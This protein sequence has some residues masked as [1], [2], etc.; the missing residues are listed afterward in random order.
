MKKKLIVN[1]ILSVM[2]GVSM[3]ACAKNSP[4]AAYTANQA[5]LDFKWEYPA[6]W[7]VQVFGEQRLGFS[8]V[9][10]VEKQ[11]PDL[12][13]QAVF[14]VVSKKAQAYNLGPAPTL[15]AVADD[16]ANRRLK[17]EG[18]RILKRDTIRVDGQTAA[19]IDVVYKALNRIYSSN[20]KK[21]T[22][23]EKIVIVPHAGTFYALRY[24]NQESE[25]PRWEKF[26]QHALK[27]FRFVNPA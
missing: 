18:A 10:F 3:T 8:G 5:G 6:G 14:G 16:A 1:L 15:E 12:D 24:T 27:A 22:L 4:Y 19:T 13:Y 2:I 23:R 26:F 11:Q 21:I 7:E 20:S 9:I 17:F 25:F